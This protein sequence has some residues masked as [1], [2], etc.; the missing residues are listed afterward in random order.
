MTDLPQMPSTDTDTQPGTGK[1][2]LFLGVMALI[3]G[4][5]ALFVMTNRLVDGPKVVTTAPEPI[6][7]L[8]QT[9]SLQ[10]H[11]TL[12]EKFTGLITPRRTS[13]LG[14]ISG[15][16]IETLGVDVGDQVSVGQRLA[17]LDIRAL[18]AQRVSAEAVI[19]EAEAAYALA[20]V[21]VER[22]RSL[23]DRG[24]VSD[25]L[26]DEANA[27]VEAARARILAAKARADTFKVQIDLAQI[28]APYNGTITQRQLDEGAIA[29]PGQPV[30]E[31]V[32]TGAL[33]AHI[34]LTAAMSKDLNIGEVYT[35]VTDQGPAAARLR[36]VTGIIDRVQRTV[37]TVFDILEPEQV[38]PGAVARLSVQQSLPA[39][40]VWLPV[41]ALTEGERGLWSVYLA[42]PDNNS[43]WRA[44]PGL[45]DIIHQTG[46]RVY[47][48]GAL[49]QGDRLILNGLQRLTPGQEVTPQAA[50]S[51]YP[52]NTAG[53]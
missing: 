36:S 32:E 15:G 45:V 30:L 38:A 4:A 53:D 47:V 17:S 41:S 28:T 6:S 10:T 48:R 51:E 49:S 52:V 16:R 9:V 14:F 25:Q 39:E 43:T 46:E 3:A 29:A 33:E 7:V 13:Q 34:G 27:Q 11:F 20:R 42:R 26:V 8:T 5:I 22:Q 12:S 21:T 37:T 23:A 35:L 31:L 50:P 24:H 18:Q 19:A 40:G 1:G 44:E 2:L